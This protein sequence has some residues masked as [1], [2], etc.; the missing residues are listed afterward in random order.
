MT[1]SSLTFLRSVPQQQANQ[2][3][4]YLKTTTATR[5]DIYQDG[6]VKASRIAMLAQAALD[7]L[8]ASLNDANTAETKIRNAA[9][10]PDV[11]VDPNAT[12]RIKFALDRG[13]SIEDI[14]RI[15]LS[16]TDT[17]GFVALR[18]LLPYICDQEQDIKKYGASI[19][20]YESQLFTPAQQSLVAELRE[21]EISMPLLRQNYND[22]QDFYT[23]QLGVNA[24][25]GMFK[26]LEKLW[27]WQGLPNDSQKK[28]M[29]PLTDDFGGR[30]GQLVTA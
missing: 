15:L 9:A 4:N 2:Y 8:L 18:S 26:R 27:L 16:T 24:V 11:A 3:N 30:A 22:L 28:G 23:L 25:S 19:M 21:C 7:A 1:S 29:L 13:K 12:E 5:Q 14:C 10:L 20:A 6:Q 17:A